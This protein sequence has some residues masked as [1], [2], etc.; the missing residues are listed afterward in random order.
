MPQ[1]CSPLQTFSRIYFLSEMTPEAKNFLAKLKQCFDIPIIFSSY[2]RSLTFEEHDL[3]FLEIQP[4]NTACMMEVIDDLQIRMHTIQ[5][6]LFSSSNIDISSLIKRFIVKGSFTP[7]MTLEHIKQGICK[8]DQGSFWFSRDEFETITKMRKGADLSQVSQEFELT[9]REKQI[10]FYLVNG[11]S[12][13]QMAEKLFVAENTIKTHRNRLYK[14]M[15]VGSGFEAIH[16]FH[17]RTSHS[18]I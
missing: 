9:T 11:Y 5:V 10:L 3:I 2:D 7:N 4:E 13:S 6:A 12:I 15:D 17:Q 18:V 16:L 1:D 8:I 14:K